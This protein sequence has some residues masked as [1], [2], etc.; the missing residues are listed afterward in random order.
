MDV[1]DIPNEPWPS[2]HCSSIVEL[3]EDRFM[4]TWYAGTSEAARDVCVAR[5]WFTRGSEW[6]DADVLV[7]TPDNPDGNGIL[8]LDNSKMLWFFWN[9]IR[10]NQSNFLRHGWAATDNK[11]MTSMDGGQT[12]SDPVPL[13]PEQIGWNFKNKAIY[14]SNEFILLP[15]YDELAGTSVVAISENNGLTW[16]AS[17]FIETDQD[18]PNKAQFVAPG[19]DIDDEPPLV[20]LFTNEQPTLIERSD[21][22]VLAFLRTSNLDRIHRSLSQDH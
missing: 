10:G 15:M 13:F 17:Q 11:Y 5:S 4:A 6:S 9:T 22:S 21:G 1:F 12:W 7:K 8:F 16:S 18:Q 19:Y 14:L 3:S 2:A 20:P